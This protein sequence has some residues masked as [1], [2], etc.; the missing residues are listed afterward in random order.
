MKVWERGAGLT[1][2]CGTGACAVV[3]A[4]VLSSRI[5]M[6]SKDQP[7]LV[8]LP[9]GDLT[10]AWSSDDD[11]CVNCVFMTGPAVYVFCGIIE[12]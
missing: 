5:S 3:V 7:C 9:G 8:Q 10:I 4:A 11:S 2:A 6:P 1:L 12:L